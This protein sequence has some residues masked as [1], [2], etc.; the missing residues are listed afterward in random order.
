MI[1]SLWQYSFYI[2]IR[3]KIYST[4]QK[5]Y[6]LG[7]L[8]HFRRIPPEFFLCF[9]GRS[10]MKLGMCT[11]YGRGIAALWFLSKNSGKF[12]FYAQKTLNF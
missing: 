6:F 4:P 1:V 12:L 9:H 10:S 5:L 3:N 2:K 11:P 7:P 8:W